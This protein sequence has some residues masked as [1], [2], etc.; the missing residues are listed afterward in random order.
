MNIFTNSFDPHVL[1]IYLDGEESSGHISNTITLLYFFINLFCL[2][3]STLLL[4][5]NASYVAFLLI[6]WLLPVS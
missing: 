1:E 6:G 4:E 5:A 3:D 2:I